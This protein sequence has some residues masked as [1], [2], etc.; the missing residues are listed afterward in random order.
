MVWRR[1]LNAQDRVH[2]GLFEPREVIEG[3]EHDR[4]TLRC[5]WGLATLVSRRRRGDCIELEPG[6]ASVLANYAAV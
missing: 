4:L 2:G 5:V 3:E 1:A 6:Y